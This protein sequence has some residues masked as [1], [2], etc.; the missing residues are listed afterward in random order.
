MIIDEVSMLRADLL[1]AIDT[2]LRSVKR[3]S[4][5]PFGGVQLLLIGDLMQLPPVIRDNEWN[6]LKN[7][8]ASIYFFNAKAFDSQPP[9]Q[10]EL[11]KI[12]DDPLNFTDKKIFCLLL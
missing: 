10:I 2:L 5:V 9:I 11:D 6:V 8:Y 4:Y 3:K 1:D 12:S 7:Y